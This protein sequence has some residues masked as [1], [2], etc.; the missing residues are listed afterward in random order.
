MRA[1]NKKII[2]VYEANN[3]DI[4]KGQDLDE[5]KKNNTYHLA[6]QQNFINQER[7]ENNIDLVV[8]SQT[9]Q[10]KFKLDLKCNKKK[11]IWSATIA[12][13]I[14]ALGI[15]AVTVILVLK[16]KMKEQSYHEKLV[17]QLSRE[18]NEVSRYQEV[19]KSSIAISINNSIRKQSQTIYT[20]LLFNVYDIEK[21]GYDIVYHAF[22][23]VINMTINVGDNV[24]FI[25]GLDIFNQYERSNDNDKENE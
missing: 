10:S 22:V 5:D 12:S 13:A 3:E 17:V 1:Y 15:I 14:I 19:K 20:D 2:R 16:N 18:L 24:S 23:V 11:I 8:A 6:T 9:N 4:G 7:E 21:I 25:G